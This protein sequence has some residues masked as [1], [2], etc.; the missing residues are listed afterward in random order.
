MERDREVSSRNDPE[1][2]NG[3]LGNDTEE[4]KDSE[5]VVFSLFV[6]RGSFSLLIHEN[7]CYGVI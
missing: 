5:Y 1:A 7:K 4:A 2:D 6:Y 3:N